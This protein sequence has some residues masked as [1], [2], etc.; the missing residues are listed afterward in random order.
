MT[1]LAL[2]SSAK[3]GQPFAKLMGHVMSTLHGRKP[4]TSDKRLFGQKKKRI[5][6]QLSTAL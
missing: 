1:K 2:A 3:S 4:T 6:L 5:E